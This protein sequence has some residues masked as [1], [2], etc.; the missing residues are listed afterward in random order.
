M[1]VFHEMISTNIK[2][3]FLAKI[4]YNFVFAPSQVIY[5]IKTNCILSVIKNPKAPNVFII[6]IQHLKYN[7]ISVITI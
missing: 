4:I 1:K 2:I 6:S 7:I 5:I 3:V